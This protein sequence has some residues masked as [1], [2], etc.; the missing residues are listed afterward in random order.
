M[1]EKIA[2]NR[3]GLFLTLQPKEKESYL[4]LR[5]EILYLDGKSTVS[6][7]VREMSDKLASAISTKRKV[8]IW[9]L[10]EIFSKKYGAERI[11]YNYP[12]KGAFL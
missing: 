12:D 5:N 3:T 8:T 6:D 4:T 2:I 11:L 10:G 7:I 9:C 1:I